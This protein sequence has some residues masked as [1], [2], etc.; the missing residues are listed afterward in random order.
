MNEMLALAGK[1]LKLLLRDKAGF[2]FV[3]LFPLV[4]AIGFGLMFKGPDGPQAIAVAYVD[5]DDTEASRELLAAL[6]GSGEFRM[7]EAPDRTAAENLVR[8]GKRTAYVLIPPGFGEARRR[9]FF[10]SG[11]MLELGVDPSRK[12]QAGMLQGKLL[13]HVFA[14]MTDA[15]T[16]PAAMRE[17]VREDIEKVKADAEL[18][19]AQKLILTT[20]LSSLDGFLGA[21]PKAGELA[22]EP[23]DGSGEDSDDDEGSGWQPVSVVTREVTG[24][25]SDRDLPS[26][27]AISFPQSVSWALIGCAAAFA[28]SIVTE[29]TEGTLVRLRTAPISRGQV[30]GGKALACF[31]TTLAASSVLLGVARAAFGV[32]PQSWGLLAAAVLSA[33][34]CF[35]GIMML[36]SVIGRSQAA[37]SGIGWAVMLVMA[38]LGGGMMPLEFMPG[39]M[40]TLSHVSPVKWAIHS[41]EGAIWRGFGPAEMFPACMI[42]LSVGLVTFLIGARVFRDDAA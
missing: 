26:S 29:R 10:S 8:L 38:M 34:A 19:A 42:L 21:V 9:M 25:A 24:A 4:Y 5:L 18:S 15:F 31:F 11:A 2:I 30:L 35:V 36:L 17:V 32:S 39:F 20:F 28:I 7:T 37:A 16:N 13:E 22:D 33:C 12:A 14:G 40:K 27:F 1:D 6:G 23:D 3:F 41:I